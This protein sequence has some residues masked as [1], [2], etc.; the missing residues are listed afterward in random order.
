MATECRNL[1]Q[2]LTRGHLMSPCEFLDGAALGKDLSVLESSKLARAEA[3]DV[4]LTKPS[5][6]PKAANRRSIL[7]RFVAKLT[8]LLFEKSRIDDRL[9]AGQVEI[10]IAGRPMNSTP[11]LAD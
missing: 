8:S 1:G 5:L 9:D 2:I 10:D 11:R 3:L 6:L 4:L 7:C